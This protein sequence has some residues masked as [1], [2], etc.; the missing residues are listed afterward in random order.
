[1]AK[2]SRVKRKTILFSIAIAV[3]GRKTAVNTD[4]DEED[5][6]FVVS[7]A[8]VA[9]LSVLQVSMV[10]I[11]YSER[12]KDENRY[13]DASKVFSPIVCPVRKMPS[14]GPT[15]VDDED[16]DEGTVF[17]GNDEGGLVATEDTV[18]LCSVLSNLTDCDR[19]SG[20]EDV[21]FLFDVSDSIVAG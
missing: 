20:D 12:R 21:R 19:K 2:F 7:V 6:I 13:E 14:K 1:M 8:A 16:D 17:G 15:S 9:V 5:R 4:D 11:A 10:P 18:P 3:T